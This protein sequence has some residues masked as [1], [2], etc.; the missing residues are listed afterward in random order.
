MLIAASVALTAASRF[1]L[2][3]EAH[4][5]AMTTA[6]ENMSNGILKISTGERIALFNR[7]LVTL[8]RL[9]SEDMTVGMSLETFLNCV[10]NA[11]G[12]DA[13]RIRR[14]LM[15]H[16]QW[17]ANDEETSIEHVFDD[18]RVLS[19]TCQPVNDGAVLTYDDI[20]MAR[21]AQ[22]EIAQLA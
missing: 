8:L 4:A 13:A 11:N 7:R 19:I 9:N 18:G 6:L 15:N 20:S 17:M 2:Q 12:W 3:A 14:V 22:Y 5:R 16:R 1:D 10:G 21:Q